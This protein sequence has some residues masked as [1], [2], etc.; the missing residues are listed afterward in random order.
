M[1]NFCQK[2]EKVKDK[3]SAKWAQI[4]FLQDLKF[5]TGII[6]FTDTFYILAKT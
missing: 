3:Y 6:Q 5:E 4:Q 2:K 1:F